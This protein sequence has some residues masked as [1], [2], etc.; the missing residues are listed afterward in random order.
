MKSEPSA[1]YTPWENPQ[2]AKIR[3]SIVATISER[4][5]IR[6]RQDRDNEVVARDDMT[7][8]GH[9]TGLELSSMMD[10]SGSMLSE[11]IGHIRLQADRPQSL[12]YFILPTLSLA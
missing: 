11:M 3:A 5:N 10:Y 2:R 4:E 6:G 8:V 7:R 12:R 9:D 1:A